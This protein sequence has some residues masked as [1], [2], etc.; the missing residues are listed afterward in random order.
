M[1]PLIVLSPAVAKVFA[2]NGWKKNDIRKYLYDNVKMPAGLME[3]YARNSAFATFSLRDLV[4]R[5]KI[6]SDYF[7][8]DDPQR[9][10][11]VFYKLEWTN[12][13]VAGDPGR[14]QSRGYCQSHRHGVPVSKRIGLP[15]NW[16][17][18]LQQSKDL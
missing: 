5:G 17:Q 14:N 8:S 9:L 6:P 12:F 1:F 3:K 13:V 11:R 18:M 2:D 15:D 7:E 16:L 10:V 4:E